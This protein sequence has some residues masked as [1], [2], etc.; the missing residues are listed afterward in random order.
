MTRYRKKP[1][2]VD[3]FRLGY[4]PIPD[5][6]MVGVSENQHILKTNKE[7]Y[8]PYEFD[9]TAFAEIKTLEG[10]MTANNGDY[11]IQGVSGEVYPCKP[12]IFE[13]TYEKVDN[14]IKALEKE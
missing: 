2:I 1:V 4:E 14:A 13:A 7:E 10:I 8:F 5:W 6:F 11:V 9:E 12:D 3:V